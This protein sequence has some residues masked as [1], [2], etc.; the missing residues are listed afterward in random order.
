MLIIILDVNIMILPESLLLG[1]KCVRLTL[2]LYLSNFLL[3]YRIVITLLLG[4]GRQGSAGRKWQP[5]F[6]TANDQFAFA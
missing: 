3:G 6:F 5:S 4:A 2:F 1:S